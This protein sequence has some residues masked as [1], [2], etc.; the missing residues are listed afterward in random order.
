MP[1]GWGRSRD[2]IAIPF[3]RMLV[4]QATVEGLAIAT[5]DL[6]MRDYGVDIIW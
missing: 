4:A 1:C 5:N 6:V 2:C 3:D